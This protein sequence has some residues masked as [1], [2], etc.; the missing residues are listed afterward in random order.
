MIGNKSALGNI[1]LEI[2]SS[3]LYESVCK[4]LEICQLIGERKASLSV[5]FFFSKTCLIK[6]KRG[7]SDADVVLLCTL[8]CVSTGKSGRKKGQILKGVKCRSLRSEAASQTKDC[9]CHAGYCGLFLIFSLE[10]CHFV[11]LVTCF[12]VF[13]TQVNI[14]FV[15][16][17]FQV[18]VFSHEFLQNY[19]EIA[20]IMTEYFFV[21][22]QEKDSILKVA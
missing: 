1:V 3:T 12:F 20:L 15:D 17:S 4:K 22:I 7:V 11:S 2:L 10:L 14:C 19:S 21:K 16:S 8:Y 5:S 9:H 6:R 18:L 13:K